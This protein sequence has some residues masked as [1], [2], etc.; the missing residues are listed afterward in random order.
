MQT[1]GAENTTSCDSSRLLHRRVPSQ[2][3]CDRLP[4]AVGEATQNVAAADHNIVVRTRYLKTVVSTQ[5]R[6]AQIS[7]PTAEGR[8]VYRQTDYLPRCISSRE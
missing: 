3:H 2:T 5:S 7:S 4:A 6:S 8:S 1:S